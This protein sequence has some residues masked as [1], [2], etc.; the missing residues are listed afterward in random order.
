MPGNNGINPHLSAKLLTIY[1]APKYLHGLEAVNIHQ[2]DIAKLEKY[3]KRI[4]KQIQHLPECTADE[5][6]YLLAGQLPIQGVL[7]KKH[8]TLF[9]AIAG[10]DS[11]ER[12][13]AC[14]QLDTKKSNLA[15][16]SSWSILFS[17]DMGF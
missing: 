4:L 16:G 13:I 7:D 2:G 11:T 9:G 3:H 5:A 17:P 10:S 15:V 8:L 6:V 1:A 12:E 14:R